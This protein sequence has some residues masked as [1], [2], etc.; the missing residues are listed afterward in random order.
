MKCVFCFW[1]PAL[2]TISFVPNLSIEAYRAHYNLDNVKPAIHLDAS[3]PCENW[4]GIQPEGLD[5]V[6]NI[7][8]IHISP[9]AC[10]EVGPK[11]TW[12]KSYVI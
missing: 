12:V 10:T 4:G 2:R 6:V 1:V 5:L 7:N 11:K 8:M 3:L 9:M